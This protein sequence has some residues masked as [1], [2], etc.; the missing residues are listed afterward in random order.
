MKSTQVEISDFLSQRSLAVVGV[1]RNA[2]KF[3]NAVY[4][5]LKQQGYKVFPI[6]REAES[7]EGDRCYP[8]IKALPE[9]VGGVVICIPPVQT[10]KI[11]EDVLAADI[12]HVWLQRGAE[13]YAALRFCEK[14]GITAIHGECILMFAEPVESIHRFHRWLVKLFGMYPTGV[15]HREHATHER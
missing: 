14:N 4:R 3:G 9:K 2:K 11:L 15:A 5:T 13:S 6:H 12:S 8:N 7:I 10:E 1:S